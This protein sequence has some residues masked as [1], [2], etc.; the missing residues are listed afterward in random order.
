MKF[1]AIIAA[2]L[3]SVNIAS[4][5]TVCNINAGSSKDMVFDKILYSGEVRGPRFFLLKDS[6]QSVEEVNLDQM[7]SYEKW[8]LINGNTFVTFD[9]EDDGQASIAIGRVDI[10][11]SDNILPLEAITVGM[12]GEQKFLNL[13]VP[14]KDL[15]LLCSSSK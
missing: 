12:L 1:A 9:V 4:A 6:L 2:A 3:A 8:K 10:S 15:S 11:K 7:N 14:Q 13:I 5:K